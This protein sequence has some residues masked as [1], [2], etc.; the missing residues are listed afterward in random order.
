MTSN[1]GQDVVR[2]QL[3]SNPV[4]K[5]CNLCHVDLCS[6][7]TLTHMADLTTQ[8]DV[9]DFI[10][11]REAQLKLP[12]CKS[13]ANKECETFCNDCH[14]PTCQSCVKTKHKMHDNS[15]M[16]DVIKKLKQR[17]VNDVNE[18]E[19]SICPNYK[20]M[21]AGV[22]YDEVLSVIQTQEDAICKVVRDIC[23]QL[24]NKVTEQKREYHNKPNEIKTDI[25]LTETELGNVINNSKRTLR[26]N[27]AEDILNYQSR[28]DD[29]RSV[30]KSIESSFPKFLPGKISTNHITGV[31]GLLENHITD[32]QRKQQ[33][34]LKLRPTPCVESS[35]YS[36]LAKNSK[37]WRIACDGK[38]KIWTG[39]DNNLIRQIDRRGSTLK[40]IDTKGN[41]LALSVSSKQELVFFVGWETTKAHRYD[42]NDITT[43]LE[44]SHWYLR[45]L[46]HTA[47]GNILVSM[48]SKNFSQSRVIQVS[49]K[50][51]SLIAQHDSQGRPLFSVEDRS[52]L[53]LTE[54][55]N[56]D[57]CVADY[58]G[59]NVVVVDASGILRF[60]YK[61]NIF[62]KSKYKSFKP[63]KI[64]NDGNWHIL[65]NDIS[66]DIVHIIDSD[67]NFIRYIEYPC[68]GG[69]SVDQDSN[70]LLGEKDTGKIRIIKYLQ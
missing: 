36:P 61:G 2:C 42:G 45:G 21:K 14:Q 68:N 70:L 51:E 17:I 58:D 5:H 30:A 22:P 6:T 15:R 53:L 18:L 1:Q 20:N 48:R 33:R 9:V 29:F 3:C 12:Q 26:L 66:N 65:V 7:C 57:I 19:N 10:N 54:N 25:A 63:S 40:T 13:H 49:G 31:F 11:K 59:E 16:Q 27:D 43:F 37:L 50:T 4:E 62:Q 46:C 23:S 55:G 67:G 32:T 35:F 39:G 34:T 8:H 64:A 24:K 52:M 69:L 44:V 28:N 60:K 38:E 56:G 47:E 41:A